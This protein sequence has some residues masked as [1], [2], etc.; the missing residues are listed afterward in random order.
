MRALVLCAGFG[1]RLGAL[2]EA[3]P[4]PLLQAG[5]RPLLFWILDELRRAGVDEVLINIHFHGNAIREATGDGAAFGLRIQYVDEEMLLGTA[6]T[7]AKNR[8]FLCAKGP[9]LLHYGDVV[10]S[11]DLPGLVAHHLAHSPLAT[12]ALHQRARSS[13]SHV[14]LSPEGRITSFHERPDEQTRATLGSGLVFSGI[15][16]IAPA[17]VDKIPPPPCDLPRDVFAKLAASGALHGRLL[18]GFRVAVDSPERLAELDR[19]LSAQIGNG[20]R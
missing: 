11:G 19:H 13:N 9:F 20:K 17:L 15:A 14:D 2:T 3:V 18:G 4:K 5:G 10:H 8:A 1:S 12:L 16:T 7:V 6:G